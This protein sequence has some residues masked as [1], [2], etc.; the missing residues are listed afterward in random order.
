[1][2]TKQDHM[3]DPAQL[4]L[5]KDLQPFAYLIITDQQ[6]RIQALSDNCKDFCSSLE[7]CLGQAMQTLFQ[8][9]FQYWTQYL[10]RVVEVDDYQVFPCYLVHQE[11]FCYLRGVHLPNDLLAFELEPPQ[12]YHLTLKKSSLSIISEFCSRIQYTQDLQ[13]ILSQAVVYLRNTFHFDKAMIYQFDDNMVATIAAESSVQS[14]PSYLG[15][16][17]PCPA[18]SE[19]TQQIF[20]QLPFR[21]IPDIHYEGVTITACEGI[22][23][24]LQLISCSVSPVLD[25]HKTYIHN[26]GASGCMTFPLI[27]NNQLWGLLAFH[28]RQAKHILPPTRQLM[29]FLADQLALTIQNQSIIQMKTNTDKAIQ[30]QRHLKKTIQADNVDIWEALDQNKSTIQ[31][32]LQCSGF[33]LV[34]N[35]YVEQ[36]GQTPSTPRIIAFLKWVQIKQ[37]EY[38]VTNHLTKLDERF[39]DWNNIACGVYVVRL[40]MKDDYYLIF[41][42]PESRTELHWVG[43]PNKPYYID[44]QM[45]Q[46]NPKTAFRAWREQQ[47]NESKPWSD[48]DDR[49]ITFIQHAVVERLTHQLLY[50]S[51]NTDP[52][53]Q[54]YNRRYL[55][56]KLSSMLKHSSS[57]NDFSVIMFDIDYFKHLNDKFGHQAGDYV[58]KELVAFIQNNLRKTDLIARYGGEEFLAILDNCDCNDA[59][60]IADNLRKKF[61]QLTWFFNG[62]NI[63]PIYV[64]AGVASSSGS[65]HHIDEL[66]NNADKALYQAKQGGR[67]KVVALC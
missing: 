12:S 42:R 31:T 13:R 60:Q 38:F 64:S 43:D 35:Q 22:Q 9:H 44:D 11:Q 17:F 23:D 5:T 45:G 36:Y 1:M 67:N 15:L 41:F 21:Y 37:S 8:G 32:M 47:E 27:V 63:G 2:I 28:H 66:I 61:G 56:L 20:K 26:M 58:L 54:A 14:L 24:Q 16:K 19:S 50:D 51:A 46:Y 62:Q 33:A 52:L 3:S 53:T 40:L 10:Q 55:F 6:Y 57:E 4:A 30:L 34:A 7:G 49:A 65:S 48:F 59:T 39:E 29:R 18:A 25:R